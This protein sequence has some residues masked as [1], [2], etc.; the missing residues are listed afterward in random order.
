LLL[1]VLLL[2]ILLDHED[3]GDVPPKR[4]AFTKYTA[5]NPED[6]VLHLFFINTMHVIRPPYVQFVDF[7]YFLLQ[8]GSKSNT[9]SEFSIL[10]LF[11]VL[12]T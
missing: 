7:I 1:S 6:L 9:C 12:F 3:E 5:Y 4:R 8:C 2:W 11:N 10:H